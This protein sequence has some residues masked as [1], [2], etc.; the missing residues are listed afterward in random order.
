MVGGLFGNED[1]IIGLSA[2]NGHPYSFSAILNGY[3]KIYFR[4]SGWDVILNYLE[5]E[6]KVIIWYF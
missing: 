5:K 2:N 4:Q 1:G 6:K 3:D